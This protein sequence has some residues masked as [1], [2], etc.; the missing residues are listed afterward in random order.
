MLRRIVAHPRFPTPELRRAHV[1]TPRT[2][3]GV[4]RDLAEEQGPILPPMRHLRL[5]PRLKKM[6]ERMMQSF[7]VMRSSETEWD[8]LIG[9][10]SALTIA[11]SA[12]D[13]FRMT[14]EWGVGGYSK[15][16]AAEYVERIEDSRDKRGTGSRIQSG[17]AAE[18]VV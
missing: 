16:N 3:V 17:S 14:A 7:A 9:S 2:L 13:F 4:Q 6:I 11:D 18:N 8:A 10:A 15:N 1:T 5:H 12:H